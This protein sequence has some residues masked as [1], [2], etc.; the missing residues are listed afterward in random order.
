[1]TT[2]RSIRTPASRRLADA[3]GS[4][5]PNPEDTECPVVSYPLPRP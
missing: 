2:E 3:D 4:P 1:M 5:A